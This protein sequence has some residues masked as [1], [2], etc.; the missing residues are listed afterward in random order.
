MSLLRTR[1]N[2]AAITANTRLVAQTLGP[3]TRLM[4]V[5]KA[6]GYNHGAARVA[7][8]MAAGGAQCF[9]VATIPEAVALRDQGVTAPILAWIWDSYNPDA[10]T[11]AI[12]HGI[13]LGVP[14]MKHLRCLIDSGIHASISLEVETG[15]HR[16]G[17]DPQYWVEAFEMLKQAPQLKVRGVFSHFAC[18]DEPQNPANA[19]QIKALE[20]AIAVGRKHGFELPVN[21]LANSA[22]ALDIPQ[23]RFEQARVGIAL[24][25]LEPGDGN[26]GLTPA[27]TWSADVINVKFLLSGESVSYG[28]IYTAE[29]DEYLALV[30]VGYADGL[31]RALSQKLEITIR[32]NRYRQVGRVCMDQIVVSLGE[33]TEGI[34][35]GDEA[36]IFGPGD[37][38][39]VTIDEFAAQ[40]G[41]INYEVLNLPI[42][43]TVR[44][45]AHG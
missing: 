14:S 38:G 23:S 16:S 5:V 10:V 36:I 40:L 41:T 2:L 15:M 1:I 13:E 30:P 22:G 27:M 29:K 3:D 28:H 37:S 7:E 44:T 26:H 12:A 45:Y 11:D 6:D 31:P 19:E 4:A 25:G 9:G 18:A 24:Y 34:T 20:E 43:R 8:A 33:N 39:E 35:Q 32:G 21:H 42:G 17:I